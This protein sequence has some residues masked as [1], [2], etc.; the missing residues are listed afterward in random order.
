MFA[1]TSRLTLRPGWPED[2][3]A[4]ARAIGHESVVTKL[5][6]APWPYRE[7]D[8]RAFLALPFSPG[9]V[10]LLIWAHENAGEP[11]L[12]GGIALEADGEA[13][14]FGYW[15][16]PDAWGRGYATEA[17]RA[18][19]AMARHAL[20][21]RRLTAG[22]FVDNPA[23]GRVLAK[24]G[25]RTAGRRWIPCVARGHPVEAVRVHLALDPEQD[26]TEDGPRLISHPFQPTAARCPSPP[27]P[28][29]A[30]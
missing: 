24:L 7:Q 27:C 17:G 5:S 25:F 28:F 6:K 13:A 2:A 18:V 30:A 4:L 22:W 9:G 19:I 3:P 15:L 12:V 23:S 11:R 29:V 10:R 14:E 8:A 20:P 26:C 16:T 1:R 21:S